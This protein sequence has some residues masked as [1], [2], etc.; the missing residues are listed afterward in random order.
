M[1][2]IEQLQAFVATVESGSFSAAARSLNKVQSAI[3]QHIINLEIDSGFDLFDR[4]GRY[5]VLTNEGQ[6]LLPHARAT[7]Q[8]HDRLKQS[9]EQIF[10][11]EQTNLSIAIDEGIPTSQLYG[12]IHR[13]LDRYPG[14]SFEFLAASSVDVIELVVSK[15][16]TTGILF[17]ELDLPVGIDFESVGSIE[18]DVYV[19]SQHELAKAT[20]PNLENLTLHRQLLIRSKTAKTSSF[21]KA[22][23]PNV[24]YA[25]NYY[26]LM[27]LINRGFGW[28]VLPTHMVK[29]LLDTGDVV[30]VPV[31]FERLTWHGN[32]DVIQHPSCSALP[33]HKMLR[34]EI[35]DLIT[36]S[37]M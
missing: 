34:S 37:E 10:N 28:G 21:Q 31:E 20:S 18:F 25:D 13:L 15:R 24:W 4:T 36:G 12:A 27:D 35:R 2:S 29:P 26:I 5:P 14:V 33:I 23:S 32:V 30:R 6:Q 22:Y 19:S 17:S 7:L 3:S 8:Q 9:A 11:Q 1:F 16:A